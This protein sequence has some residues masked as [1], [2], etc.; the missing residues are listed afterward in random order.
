MY[1]GDFPPTSFRL[2]Q[3]EN[4][5]SNSRLVMDEDDNGKF[6]LAWLKISYMHEENSMIVNFTFHRGW[7]KFLR[8]WSLWDKNIKLILKSAKGYDFFYLFILLYFAQYFFYTLY[9]KNNLTEMI[10]F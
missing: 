2:K 8:Y 3:F 9:I 5:D 10:Y 4:R 1:F 6:R 7:K